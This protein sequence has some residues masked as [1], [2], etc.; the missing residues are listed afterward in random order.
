V[1]EGSLSHALATNIS[2]CFLTILTTKR[3]SYFTFVNHISHHRNNQNRE[4]SNQRIH[5]TKPQ[6]K[7]S[8]RSRS[9]AIKNDV[10]YDGNRHQTT[11]IP[12]ASNPQAA[13]ALEQAAALRRSL[14]TAEQKQRLHRK[15]SFS[16]AEAFV[17]HGLLIDPA[18]DQACEETDT[19]LA[20]N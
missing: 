11:D 4:Q 5:A 17:L 8:E 10:S 19:L 9:F 12:M 20:A 6:A 14:P 1:D 7:P 18:L 13:G 2:H 15:P 3:H 16:P